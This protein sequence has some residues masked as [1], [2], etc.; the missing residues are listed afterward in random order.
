MLQDGPDEVHQ[1]D[2]RRVGA[3][4]GDVAGF[5]RD[6][7]L[8]QLQLLAGRGHL[9]EDGLVRRGARVLDLDLADSAQAVPDGEGV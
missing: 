4:D 7:G 1:R 5:L 8:G 6:G 9:G 2:G 3:G